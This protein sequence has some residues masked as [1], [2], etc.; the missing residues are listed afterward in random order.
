MNKE[1]TNLESNDEEEAR[2]ELEASADVTGR[3]SDDGNINDKIPYVV[4]L[5]QTYDFEG[6]KISEVDL[7]GL[8]D[9]TTA[10]AEYIERVMDKLRHHPTDKFRDYT[11]TKHI[12]MK[13]TNL[14]IEF[15]NSLKW[16]DMDSVKSRVAVYF[17]YI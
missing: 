16:K 4:K 11:Y 9:L 6:E 15:F 5:T 14:P 3:D 1:N 10:D 8:E 13:V 12:A 7:S 2:A 17:L